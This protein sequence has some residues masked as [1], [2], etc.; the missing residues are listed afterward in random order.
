M[1]IFGWFKKKNPKKEEIG[2]NFKQTP[3][4][5]F[6]SKVVKGRRTCTRDYEESS[7]KLVVYNIYEGY[8]PSLHYLKDSK[9]CCDNVLIMDGYNTGFIYDG[10]SVLDI[11]VSQYSIINVILQYKDR[12]PYRKDATLEELMEKYPDYT[13]LKIEDYVRHKEDFERLGYTYE[14]RDNQLCLRQPKLS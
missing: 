1:G 3:I 7:K 11:E 5:E 14:I 8:V 6:L 4:H 2:K 10:V 9:V 12:S 13:I